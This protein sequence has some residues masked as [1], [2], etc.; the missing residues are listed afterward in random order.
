MVLGLYGSFS[1]IS[2]LHASLLPIANLYRIFSI[3]VVAFSAVLLI[4]ENRSLKVPVWKLLISLSVLALF[5]IAAMVTDRSY[6]TAYVAFVLIADRCDF[7]KIVK[8]S[9][10]AAL[11][12]LTLI[13]FFCLVGI[14]TDH[15]Y[16]GTGQRVAHCLG[17]SYYSRFPFILFLCTIMFL[18]LR[19][20]KT[21]LIYALILVINIVVFYYTTLRLT[22]YLTFLLVFLDW[23]LGRMNKWDLSVGKW[24]VV[25]ACLYPICLAFTWLVMALYNPGNRFLAWLNTALNNRIRLMHTGY[26]EYS[27][28]L[29]GNYIAMRGNSALRDTIDYFYIDSGF[30]YSLLA[31]GL[32]FTIAVVFLYS[33]IFYYS[34]RTN[35]KNL[36]I[37][38]FV[39]MV[40]TL[41]NNIWLSVTYNP[42]LMLSIPVLGE[43]RKQRRKS[44]RK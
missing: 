5:G 27:V 7:K 23:L 3:A 43:I 14:L 6:L 35:N 26:S 8:V 33:S 31:Y 20:R 36:F 12:A 37:W 21:W 17:F 24:P 28:K 4:W 25:S 19:N 15:L 40:F 22:Y 9:L 11:S 29:F 44:L 32:V 30:A 41:V 1:F 13:L 39:I 16:Y 10:I 18:Y 38:T 42:L 34:C 2:I